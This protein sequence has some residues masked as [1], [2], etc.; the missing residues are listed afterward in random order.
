MEFSA[1]SMTGRLRAY[2]SLT[3]MSSQR[4]SKAFLHS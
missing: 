3:L 1:A 4:N 2:F